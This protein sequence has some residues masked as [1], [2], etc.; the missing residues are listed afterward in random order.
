[1]EKIKD[2]KIN[3]RTL[4]IIPLGEKFSICYELDD[5]LIIRRRPNSII[6]RNCLNYGSSIQGR[7]NFTEVETGY[8]YKAPILVKE[9]KNL[10]FFPTISPRKKNCGWLNL[11]NIDSTN[12]DVQKKVTKVKFNSGLELEFDI[13]LNIIN[14]QILRA[15]RLE[16]KLRRN[17]A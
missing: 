12:Y 14:N 11:N 16:S 3:E 13:S 6:C 8:T 2:Y 4:A 1:M 9:D 10:I 17:Y 5:Y 15:T 7:R